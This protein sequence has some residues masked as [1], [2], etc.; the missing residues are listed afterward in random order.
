MLLTPQNDNGQALSEYKVL[1]RSLKCECN[2]H[3]AETTRIN[4]FIK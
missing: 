4:S 2:Q 1:L 3:F